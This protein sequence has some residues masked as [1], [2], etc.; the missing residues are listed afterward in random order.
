MSLLYQLQVLNEDGDIEFTAESL[1]ADEMISAIGA[2]ERSL[3][4]KEDNDEN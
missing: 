2:F 1:D 4:L 3:P